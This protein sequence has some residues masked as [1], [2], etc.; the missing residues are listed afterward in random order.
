MSEITLEFKPVDTEPTKAVAEAVTTSLKRSY[1]MSDLKKEQL[2]K[3]RAR[4]LELRTALNAIKP[5][6]VKPVKIKQPSK[7]EIEISEIQATKPTEPEPE[8]TPTP[9]QP[10]PP[11]PT[12]QPEPIPTPEP[13]LV[14]VKKQK[15]APIKQKRKPPP[16]LV[17]PPTPPTPPPT[18]FQR[19]SFGFYVL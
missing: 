7:M 5:P 10:T 14:K 15:E 6:K 8:P 1:T 11:E 9:E 4:A 12:E 2:V 3:A 19:N 18:G 13:K 17:S 16:L